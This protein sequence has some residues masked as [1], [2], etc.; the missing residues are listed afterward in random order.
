ME[1]EM[2]APLFIL[3][4]GRS[5]TSIVCAMLGQHPQMYGLPELNLCTTETMRQWWIIHR[6]GRAVWAHGLLRAVAQL[7][8]G[9]QTEEPIEL[10]WWW[11]RRRLSWNTSSMFRHLAE[12]IDPLMLVE[13]SPI[14]VSQP[15]YLQRLLKTFPQAKFIHL[16]RHPRA[17]CESML[18]MPWTRICVAYGNALDCS[19][20]PP[21]LDP[22]RV[23]YVFHT[24]ICNFLAALPAA[25][26]IRIRGEDILHQPDHHLRQ[27]VAW[28]ELCADSDAIEQMKHPERSPFAGFGP[29]GARFGNDPSFLKNPAI[30]PHRDSRRLEDR[31]KPQSLE[32]PLSWREDGTG[33]SPKVKQLAREFGYT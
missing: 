6:R 32:G 31:V 30:R 19:I 16:L 33:F 28:L 23:W 26:K 25:Q 4:P 9:G 2:A 27:I 24:H 5:F 21:I 7:Y 12:K 1:N 29:L 13:K 14:T 20:N 11:V 8:F 10:A 22:Q 17:N 3:A 15:A 18:A